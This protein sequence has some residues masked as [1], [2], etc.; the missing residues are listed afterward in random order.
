MNTAKIIAV[1]QP[2]DHHKRKMDILLRCEQ[3]NCVVNRKWCFAVTWEPAVKWLLKRK[4]VILS[5]FKVNYKS[6][7]TYL[8]ITEKGKEWKSKQR[9]TKRE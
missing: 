3:G 4:Y 5:R 9:N 7:T 1:T 8:T 2:I 6:G